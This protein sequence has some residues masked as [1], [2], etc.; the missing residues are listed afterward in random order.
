MSTLQVFLDHCWISKFPTLLVTVL[1][2]SHT[3]IYLTCIYAG[4]NLQRMYVV[5]ETPSF[6]FIT[7]GSSPVLPSPSQ[8][9]VKHLAQGPLNRSWQGKGGCRSLTPA[10]MVPAG[11]SNLEPSSNKPSFLTFRMLSS[12]FFFFFEKSCKLAVKSESGVLHLKI[13]L[14]I[15]I[16]RWTFTR[17]S[18]DPFL[19]NWGTVCMQSTLERLSKFLC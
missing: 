13:W 8:I 18:W 7:S 15:W 12:L 1:K 4:K 14:N 19:F 5:K 11:V 2:F 10:K 16:I 6:T 9:G 3:D 17:Y